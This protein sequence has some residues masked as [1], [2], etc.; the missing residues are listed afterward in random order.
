MT[1]LLFSQPIKLQNTTGG[2]NKQVK[3]YK[4]Q[5]WLQKEPYYSDKPIS[6]PSFNIS[7][8]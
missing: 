5:P 4:K 8:S 6:P 3:K 7:K 1:Q 2:E